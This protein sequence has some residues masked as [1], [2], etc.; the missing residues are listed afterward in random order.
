[1]PVKKV[2]ED[3]VRLPLNGIRFVC[4]VLLAIH[5]RIAMHRMIQAD[6]TRVLAGFVHPFMR[7]LKNSLQ[8]VGVASDMQNRRLDLAYA[9]H[10]ARLVCVLS[11]DFDVLVLNLVTF[12]WR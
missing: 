3:T 6:P 5:N 4:A 1:M 11:D 2:H 7:K 8:M 9:L 10:G 12:A